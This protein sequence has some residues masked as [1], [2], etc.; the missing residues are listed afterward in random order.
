M[1]RTF[2]EWLQIAE[3]MLKDNAFMHRWAPHTLA[4]WLRNGCKCA[5]CDRDLLESRAITY[6]FSDRDHILP[7][8]KYPSLVSDPNNLVPACAACNTVKGDWDGDREAP[9][10]TQMHL[11]SRMAS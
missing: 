2:D 6:F 1:E 4:V 7:K 10:V 11:V 8:S 5:Y 3:Q 9:I